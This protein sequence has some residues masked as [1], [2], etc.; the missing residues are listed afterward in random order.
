MTFVALKRA[1]SMKNIVLIMLLLSLVGCKA[2]KSHVV[3]NSLD[4][5]SVNR[6]KTN[7]DFLTVS[8]KVQNSH[9]IMDSTWTNGIRLVNFTGMISRYGDIEGKADQA[10]VLQSGQSKKEQNQNLNQKD[11]VV[12]Q[13]SSTTESITEVK[14]RST[15]ADKETKGIAVPWYIWLIGL[16]AVAYGGYAVYNRIKS[17]LKPF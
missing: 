16:G 5:S 8:T 12:D 2:K 10:E 7:L 1:G 6:E 15:V 4:S 9:L 17:K 14:Q 3:K 13:S 11:S